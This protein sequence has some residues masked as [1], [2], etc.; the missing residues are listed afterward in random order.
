[1]FLRDAKNQN[2]IL[3]EL[4]TEI[5]TNVTEFKNVKLDFLTIV[6][7]GNFEK[8]LNLIIENKISASNNFNKNFITY[9][10]K[11]DNKLHRGTTKEKFKTLIK[12]VFGKEIFEIVT[13]EE[14]VIYCDFM[15]FRHAIAHSL[16]TYN[17]KKQKL[18][19]NIK[20]TDEIIEILEKVLIN[21]KKI[22]KI[23]INTD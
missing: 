11:N 3:K 12:E 4:E 22:K 23:K 15:E 21:L 5:K 8:D 13:N 10:R 14:W 19:P 2:Q 18:I 6:L 1:M 16:P 17:S 7:Y 9:L 20:D